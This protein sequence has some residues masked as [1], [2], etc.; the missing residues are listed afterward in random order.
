MVREAGKNRIRSRVKSESASIFVVLKNEHDKVRRL[1][2]KVFKQPESSEETFSLIYRD[3]EA[4]MSGEEQFFYPELESDESIREQVL[5]AYEEH[6]MGKILLNELEG[7]S[8]GDERWMAKLKVLGEIISHH[9]EEEE[10]SIFPKARKILGREGEEEIARHY[11]AEKPD[12]E[13]APDI[14]TDEEGLEEF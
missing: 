10:S 9:I 4:H 8:S 5:E 13:T 11:L 6:N 14:V 12:L 2:D 3:L 7:M 1:F